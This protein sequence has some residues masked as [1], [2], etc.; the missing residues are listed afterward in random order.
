[1]PR[2]SIALLGAFQATLD[3]Q[4][5]S[6]LSAN[7]ARALLAYLAVEA[8]RAH[9]R[10]ALAALLWPDCP[11]GVALANL[12]YALFELREALGDRTATRPFL[13]VARDT[14]QFNPSSDHWLDVRAFRELL[15]SEEAGEGPR[16]AMQH[17]VERLEQAL[18]LYRGDLLA[19]FSVGDSAPFEEWLTL[20]RDE[21]AR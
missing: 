14:L 6:G 15:S 10:E 3:G 19:G 4:P 13:L 5:M 2:L 17:S 18:A 12:R 7:K 9:T 16:D 1:M 21:F 20:R 8:A 11:D